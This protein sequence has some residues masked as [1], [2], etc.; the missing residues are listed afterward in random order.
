MVYYADEDDWEKGIMDA[1]DSTRLKY[2]SKKPVAFAE[3]AEGDDLHTGLTVA[4]S[5]I[6]VVISIVDGLVLLIDGVF[7]SRVTIE[8]PRPFA[9][10]TVPLRFTKANSSY[11]AAIIHHSQ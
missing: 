11:C 6:A 2:L 1:R 5:S 3:F 4:P 10:F 7:V 9:W 8:K